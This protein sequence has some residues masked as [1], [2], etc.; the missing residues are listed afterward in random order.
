MLTQFFERTELVFWNILI[1]AM[2]ESPACRK[3]IQVGSYLAIKEYRNEWFII[4][5]L[6]SIAG[7]LSG[8]ALQALLALG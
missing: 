5:G 2:R 8:L 7:F 4:L 3:M 1:R 6:G